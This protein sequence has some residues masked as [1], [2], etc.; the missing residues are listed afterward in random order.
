VTVSSELSEIVYVACKIALFEYVLY[1][2]SI[3]QDSGTICTL[4]MSG[5][6]P[7]VYPAAFTHSIVWYL[8]LGVY[9]MLH[10]SQVY[11]Y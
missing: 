4:D 2:P 3:R 10:F 5:F 11:Y 1:D 6:S 9:H 7:I 8:P